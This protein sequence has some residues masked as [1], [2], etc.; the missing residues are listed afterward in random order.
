[1][2]A[3]RV[4]AGLNQTEFAE[5]AGVKNYRTVLDWEKGKQMPGRASLERML[6]RLN[7]TIEQCLELPMD[8]ATQSEDE[9]ALKRLRDALSGVGPD[10]E[11]VL[12]LA[13]LLRR[14]ALKRQAEK[15]VRKQT[16]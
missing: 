10:R 7:L 15:R 16:Q 11:S 2:K 4:R 13:D 8:P 12:E 1:V 5:L 14:R 6:A 9:Q 3:C